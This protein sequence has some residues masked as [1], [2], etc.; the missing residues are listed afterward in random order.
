MMLCE[1]KLKGR[2]RAACTESVPSRREGRKKKSFFGEQDS[3]AAVS[4]MVGPPGETDNR[5]SRGIHE[6]L[7]GCAFLSLCL[8]KRQEWSG[9]EHRVLD[10]AKKHGVV[11]GGERE[12]RLLSGHLTHN[13]QLISVVQL[14]I[15]F[16]RRKLAFIQSSSQ[17]T[18]ADMTGAAPTLEAELDV[19]AHRG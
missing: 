3:R 2:G 18:L 11:A 13:S 12:A 6:R 1:F 17:R 7:R 16:G 14:C 10:A 5:C 15:F 9:V 8:E 19:Y 4:I